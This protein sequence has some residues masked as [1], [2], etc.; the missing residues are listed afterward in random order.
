M[1][2]SPMCAAEAPLHAPWREYRSIIQMLK[3]ARWNRRIFS[4]NGLQQLLFGFEARRLETRGDQR[5]R[6][7]EIA[8][9]KFASKDV[10]NNFASFAH[11]PFTFFADRAIE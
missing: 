5:L 8:H 7:F 10:A 2:W 4:R 6:A 1:N 11:C 3:P 9:R